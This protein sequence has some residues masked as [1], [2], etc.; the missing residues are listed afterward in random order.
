MGRTAC[1]AIATLLALTACRGKHE[2][3]GSASAGRVPKEDLSAQ[4]GRADGGSRPPAP[5]EADPVRRPPRAHH[6][7]RRCLR[8][9]ASDAAGRGRA[10]ARR[11]LRLRALLLR[12][13]LLEHQRPRRGDLAAA[14]AGDEAVDSRLQCAR[15]RSAESR[16][17]RL[18]RLGV[19]A[20]RS[21][22]RDA[23]RPQERHLPRHR[24]RSGPDASD[25]RPRS[26]PDRRPPPSP[27]PLAADP[28]SHPRLAE[29]PALLRLRRVPERARGDADLSR[30]RRHAPA[31]GG[32][33]RGGA[34]AARAVREARAVG[35]RHDR[36]SRTATRGAS[37]RRRARAGTSSS[38]RRTIPI[39][40][41]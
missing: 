39:A 34:H 20:G 16:H 25:Q 11:R 33:Q 7:L 30:R 6:V 15:G 14:L 17:R 29:S 10:P 2:G 38:P 28:L 36:H 26:H 1:I 24:R 13:R 18:P 32:L 19:D 27:H 22:A 4:R 40:R 8:P 41:P 9:L 23:L 5:R 35:L 12:A 37:T 21:D 3:P 31:A